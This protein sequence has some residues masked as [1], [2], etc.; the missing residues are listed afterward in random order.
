[1]EPK[2]IMESGL[3]RGAPLTVLK[4]VV[5]HRRVLSSSSTVYAET[6][7]GRC[8]DAGVRSRAPQISLESLLGVVGPP[9]EKPPSPTGKPSCVKI[10]SKGVQPIRS[11]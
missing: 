8:S 1:M 9:T 5:S 4:C 11:S 6:V 3:S 7:D 2:M 10:V